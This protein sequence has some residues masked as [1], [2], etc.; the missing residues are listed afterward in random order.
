MGRQIIYNAIQTPDGTVLESNHIHDYKEYTDK[1]GKCYIVDGGQEYL[2]R[3]CHEDQVDLTIYEDDKHDKIR[4]VFTWGRNFDEN[5]NRLPQVEYV[6][7]KDITDDHL[8]ALIP[9]TDDD[10]YPKYI[11]KVFINEKDWRDSDRNQ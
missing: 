7:L 9:W 3:T 2:R 5:M 1:N 10:S 4:E 8:E 11:N 6:K